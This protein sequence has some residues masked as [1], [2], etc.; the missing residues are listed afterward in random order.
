MQHRGAPQS[1]RAVQVEVQCT[2]AMAAMGIGMAG[3]PGKRDAG[4]AGWRIYKYI[5]VY[6]SACDA[7]P[8]VQR[9]MRFDFHA[10]RGV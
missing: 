1:A 6:C 8:N 5:G 7:N 3:E 10:S 2:L 9:L 4:G